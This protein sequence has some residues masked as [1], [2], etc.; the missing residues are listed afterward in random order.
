MKFYTV[1]F[2]IIFFACK[3][4]S[5][6]STPVSPNATNKFSI[7]GT[8]IKME[9]VSKQYIGANS[10]HS[11]SAGSSDMNSWNMDIAREFVGNVKEN[12]ISGAVIQDANGAYLHPLQNVVDSNKK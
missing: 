8:K 2:L 1:L 4:K 5:E 11:F 9:G 3:K 6:E 12:P 10:L 7:E